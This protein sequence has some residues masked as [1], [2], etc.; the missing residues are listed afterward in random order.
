MYHT[1]TS[2]QPW[3]VSQPSTLLLAQPSQM[4]MSPGPIPGEP[5]KKEK[6]ESPVVEEAPPPA[7][8]DFFCLCFF[9][10]ITSLI[11]ACV[12]GYWTASF[13]LN[14]DYSFSFASYQNSLI[15][16]GFENFGTKLVPSNFIPFGFKLVCWCLLGFTAIYGVMSIACQS[17]CNVLV[18]CIIL[19]VDVIVFT[20]LTADE[21]QTWVNVSV[22]NFKF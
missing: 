8:A 9:A 10:L 4:V 19:L 5:A 11:I 16:W 14:S 2:A 3:V 21:G 6:S 12:T 13:L 1:T 20:I 7:S 22:H 15:Q 18:L 17:R